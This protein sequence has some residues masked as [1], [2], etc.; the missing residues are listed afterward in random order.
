MIDK[1]ELIVKLQQLGYETVMDNRVPCILV[2]EMP[3]DKQKK[4]YIKLMGELGYN[5]SWGI[6][7][8]QHENRS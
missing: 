3:D 5:A 1:D 6:I 8:K 7:K 4:K 2:D